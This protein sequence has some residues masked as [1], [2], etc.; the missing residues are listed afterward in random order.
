MDKV[1]SAWDRGGRIY[2]ADGV[3]RIM[4]RD[5]YRRTA[6]TS[7]T[8]TQ[9]LRDAARLVL[10]APMT[11]S[12]FPG[13]LYNISALEY[14]WIW[15]PAKA[16]WIL[17]KFIFQEYSGGKLVTHE[18]PYLPQGE[19]FIS[20]YAEMAKPEIPVISKLQVNRPQRNFIVEFLSIMGEVLKDFFMLNGKSKK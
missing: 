7:I 11:Y 15:T 10:P 20:E 1:K 14:H 3:R 18:M 6:P 2:Y 4:D 16:K 12:P 8:H 5:M 19:G 17:E 13:K 9:V